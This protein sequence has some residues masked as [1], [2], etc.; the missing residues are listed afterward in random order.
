MPNRRNWNSTVTD[1]HQEK[2]FIQKDD[3]NNEI[4]NFKR[5]MKQHS[6]INSTAQQRKPTR[7]EF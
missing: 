4:I 2:N 6:G 1:K 7:A 3:L 5:G